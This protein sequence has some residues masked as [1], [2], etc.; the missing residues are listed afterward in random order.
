MA[1]EEREILIRQFEVCDSVVHAIQ[2]DTA[3]TIAALMSAAIHLDDIPLDPIL[4]A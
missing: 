2:S 4:L 3:V 1:G